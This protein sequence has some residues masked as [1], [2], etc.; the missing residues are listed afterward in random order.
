M[1]LGGREFKVVVGGEREGC[2]A[3]T[4]GAF[5]FFGAPTIQL[6][7]PL[8]GCALPGKGSS[9]GFQ[10]NLLRFLPESLIALE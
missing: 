8:K 1:A 5:F 9:S 7:P 2:R 4:G 10:G 3:P 6:M